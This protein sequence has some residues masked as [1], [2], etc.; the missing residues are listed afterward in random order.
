MEDPG[1]A[2][3]S[4]EKREGFYKVTKGKENTVQRTEKSISITRTFSGKILGGERC[5]R[6]KFEMCATSKW[7]HPVDNGIYGSE[8]PQKSQV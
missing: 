5:L 1:W 2:D 6:H 7:R 3:D 8:A 4:S